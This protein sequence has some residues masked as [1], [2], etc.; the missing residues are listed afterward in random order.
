MRQQRWRWVL[1]G[2]IYPLIV[3][4]SYLA[5]FLVR[6][7]FEIPPRPWRIFLASLPLVE[8]IRLTGFYFFRLHRG[9]WRYASI[10]D[11]LTIVKATTMSSLVFIA[12]AVIVFGKEYPRTVYILDWGFVTGLIAGSRLAAIAFRDLIA[13]GGRGTRSRVA[14]VGAGDAAEMLL[15]EF[16]RNPALEYRAVALV[17]DNPTKWGSRIRGIEVIGAVERL[18]AVCARLHVDEIIIAVPSATRAE[19]QAVARI[20]RSTGLPFRRV[21]DLSDLMRG[22]LK[23][24]QLQEIR[25]EDLLDR[26]VA[27]VDLTAI[28]DHL[29]GRRIIITGA[30]GSIGAE[31]A[32]HTAGMDPER[33]VLVDRADSR[34]YLL[35][36]ELRERYPNLLLIPAVGDVLSAPRMRELIREH[37]PDIVYHAAAYKHVPLMEDNPLEAIDNNVI[38]T[39]IT[40]REAARGGA[41]KFILISTDKAVEPVS[42]MG[43]TKRAAE[44]VVLSMVSD[45]MEIVAVRFGNV[46]GSDG[47]VLPL[48]KWQA[49]TRGQITVTDPEASRYF[50]LPS[51]AVHLVL[52]AGEMGGHGDI[53]F[54]HM[55]EPVRI[56]DLA[57]RFLRRSGLEPGV[58][59]NIAFSGLRPGERLGEILV[60]GREE[61]APTEHERIFRI[62]TV[63]FDRD[64]FLRDFDALK[65]LVAARDRPAAV[66]K[67]RQITFAY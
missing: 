61:L 16:E 11:L 52:T 7:D 33:L 37:R 35:A 4:A 32:R 23:A 13:R 27:V 6:F 50:M 34:L 12:A 41:R 30:A 29:R 24:A 56:V 8:L 15:R 53:F 57:D 10:S 3:A 40:A 63:G 39:E 5:A 55:G 66:E 14:V 21:P 18:P 43:M 31:L 2:T 58:D 38:G 36:L 20:C 48:F 17:D 42:V 46:L 26:D 59:V 25:P 67:L 49:A 62:R 45:T 19:L 47:S 44:L 60:A 1:L 22:K 28:H 65:Q 54:L 9:L 64:A 51:E